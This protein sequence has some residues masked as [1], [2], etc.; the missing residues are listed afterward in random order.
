MHIA[1][2]TKHQILFI[3][4]LLILM[5]IVLTLMAMSRFTAFTPDILNGHFCTSLTP[6]IQ[7]GHYILNVPI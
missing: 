5:C 4:L 6:D 2:F 7:N 3:C 1:I